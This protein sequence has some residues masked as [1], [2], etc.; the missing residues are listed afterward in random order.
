MRFNRFATGVMVDDVA[1]CR[2]F[3]VD[4][5]GC[6]AAI[7]LGW[8]VD[9]VHGSDPSFM[10]DLVQRGHDSMPEGLRDEPVAGMVLAFIVDDAEAEEAR[11]RAAGVEIVAGCKDEPWGQRHF[12][13]K[14]PGPVVELIQMIPPDPEW[15]KAHG[16]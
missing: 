1:A 2:D 13:V 14:S 15:M 9:L 5:L 6:E 12:F 11:L 16:F 10:F 4:H 3:F 8:Y 7:D